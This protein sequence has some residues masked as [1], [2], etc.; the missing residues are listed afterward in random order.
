MFVR[1]KD[2]RNRN[3]FHSVEDEARVQQIVSEVDRGN[4]GLQRILDQGSPGDCAAALQYFLIRLK[5]PLIP[6]RIQALALGTSKSKALLRIKR[7]FKLFK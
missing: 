4:N 7:D 2:V 6:H 1:M 5:K 3:L